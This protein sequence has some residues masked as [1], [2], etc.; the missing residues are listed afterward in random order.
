M[1]TQSVTIDDIVCVVNSGRHKEKSYDPYT[2]VSTLQ[3]Q[4][5]SCASERQRRGRAGRCQQARLCFGSIHTQILYYCT[6]LLAQDCPGQTR[7]QPLPLP[8]QNGPTLNKRSAVQGRE[9][10][11][12]SNMEHRRRSPPVL[13]TTILVDISV[14]ACGVAGGVLPP[15]LAR[16][17]QRPGRV[18]AARAAALPPGRAQPAGEAPN[19]L[20]LLEEKQFGG[21]CSQG[22]DN[23]K[24][25]GA[26]VKSHVGKH[27]RRQA[28]QA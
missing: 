1:R 5:I 14:Q 3:A 27:A 20:P 22:G 15:V 21:R 16:A 12:A 8:H 13:L 9:L 6:I 17:Q 24:N 25:G 2:N 10:Q 19:F 23:P 7:E 4:W 26:I 11:E 18:R 28:F